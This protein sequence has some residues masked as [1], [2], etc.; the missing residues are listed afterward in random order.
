MFKLLS[1]HRGG[2]AFGSL[3]KTFKFHF[4]YDLDYQ[5]VGHEIIHKL[6]EAMLE[7][8]WIQKLCEGQVVMQCSWHLEK[9]NMSWLS[10]KHITNWKKATKNPQPMNPPLSIAAF[11]LYSKARCSGQM[12]VVTKGGVHFLKFSKW[13][14]KLLKIVKSSKK[15]FVKT[16]IYLWKALMTTF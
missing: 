5:I 16:S 2:F 13:V 3:W 14:D 12:F 9:L 1:T 10:K 4:R 7:F 6:L 11:S 8:V 15:I